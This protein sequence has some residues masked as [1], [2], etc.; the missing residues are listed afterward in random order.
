MGLTQKWNQTPRLTA[1]GS[2]A[3]TDILRMQAPSLLRK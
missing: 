1:R 2:F 3:T